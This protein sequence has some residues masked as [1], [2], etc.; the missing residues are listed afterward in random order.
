MDAERPVEE[1]VS[2][3]MDYLKKLLATSKEALAEDLYFADKLVSNRRSASLQTIQEIFENVYEEATAAV[4]S[5]DFERAAVRMLYII[6]ETYYY[7]DIPEEI[8]LLL[9]HAL[10]V[11]GGQSVEQAAHTLYEVMDNIMEGDLSG[12][13]FYSCAD[14]PIAG[15]MMEQA[16]SA[17][18]AMQ[19]KMAE[20]MSGNDIAELQQKIVEAMTRGDM[21]EYTRLAGELQ[22]KVMS[23]LFQ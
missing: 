10:K 8:N 15:Q 5:G 20:K 22:Q 12:S 16:A 2:K 21:A 13:A 19:Q 6:Y 4:Q 11:S 1:L 18:Q 7:N 17:A 3:G 14:N 23:G 9:T